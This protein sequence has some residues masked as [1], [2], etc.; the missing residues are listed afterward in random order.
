MARRIDVRT[1]QQYQS[2]RDGG[3]SRKDA[4]WKVGISY[5]SATKFDHGEVATPEAERVM[6]AVKVIETVSEARPFTM[7]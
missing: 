1:W 7:P 2:L 6:R 3:M 4:A 5:E